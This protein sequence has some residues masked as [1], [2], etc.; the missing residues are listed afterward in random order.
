MN[1][2]VCL[3]LLFASDLKMN[4]ML[5]EVSALVTGAHWA[6][7]I[8]FANAKARELKYFPPSLKRKTTFSILLST[9]AHAAIQLGD[10]F[11]RRKFFGYHSE[12]V[13]ALI[14]GILSV[15]V[16]KVCVIGT[17]RISRAH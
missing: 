2:L 15:F 8:N 17:T 7:V 1:I 12:E 6:E 5:T 13:I 9:R 11:I 10:V 14:I 3:P 16:I 4:S